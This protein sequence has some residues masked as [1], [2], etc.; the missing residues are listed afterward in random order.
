MCKNCKCPFT[1]E[2]ALTLIDQHGLQEVLAVLSLA[3]RI[4]SKDGNHP[5]YSLVADK[6]IYLMDLVKK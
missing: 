6:L 2:K 1:I 5:G 4:T 3:A